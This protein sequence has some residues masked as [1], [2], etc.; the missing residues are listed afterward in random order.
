ML[1]KV[2]RKGN[3]PTQLVGMEIG[4]TTMENSMEVL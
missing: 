3:S 2:W 4:V 1:E